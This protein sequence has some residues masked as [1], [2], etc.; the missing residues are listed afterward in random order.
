[1][2]DT[3][4]KQWESTTS[5]QQPALR[6]GGTA[7]PPGSPGCAGEDDTT[8]QGLGGR[9]K[10]GQDWLCLHRA[11]LTALACLSSAVAAAPQK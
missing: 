6:M 9:G 7:P 11:A 3:T 4:T 10:R 2:V 1:M 8:T 5:E